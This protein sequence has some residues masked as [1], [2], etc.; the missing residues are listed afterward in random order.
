MGKSTLIWPAAELRVVW[1]LAES[2]NV[3]M[4][5]EDMFGAFK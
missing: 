3:M 1:P 4:E 2:V 5:A